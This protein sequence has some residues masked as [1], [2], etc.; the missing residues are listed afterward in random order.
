MRYLLSY[1]AIITRQFHH[2]WKIDF[3]QPMCGFTNEMLILWQDQ[4]MN[5][6][7][8]RRI[9]TL[10]KLLLTFLGYIM[11]NEGLENLAL[12]GH[13]EGKKWK[14]TWK[15]CANEQIHRER[16]KEKVLPRVVKRK[17]WKTMIIYSQKEYGIWKVGE[18]F[19]IRIRARVDKK[20]PDSGNEG[21][22]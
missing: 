4:V 18:K 10:K 11:R 12:I 17:L 13:I 8:L 20:L 5:K 7:V 19:H 21:L 15:V 3:K 16:K 22:L 6:E 2:K 14:P 1:I 9:E